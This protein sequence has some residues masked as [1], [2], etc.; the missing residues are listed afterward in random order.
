[1]NA[2]SES[3]TDIF[4]DLDRS[5]PVPLYHQLSTRIERAIQDGTLPPGA[6]LENEIALAE[7]LGL[8]R[9]TVRRAIQEIVDKG[10]LVRRR[11]I[12]T[13]VV[14]GQVSRKMALTSLFDDLA[15]AGKNPGTEVLTHE[16]VPA[17]A[18]VAAEL[19]VP[20]GSEVLH[21]RRLR[22]SEGKPLAIMDNYLPAAH[23]GIGAEDLATFGLYQIL[24][25]RG[26]N[27]RVAQ[28]RIGARLASPVEAE[29]LDQRGD[30]AVLTMTR[31]AYDN[32]GAAIE[33]SHHTFR[34]DRYSFEVTLV[35]K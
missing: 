35:D 17:P 8:S 32:A 30:T 27:L 10:L 3:P 29:L 28:Q 33:F 11:G 4:M 6:K 14:Q 13:Q 15:R 22:L 21:I 24:R 2:Q 34:P 5:G 7:R 16:V 1:M 18:E 9:P 26:V 12:G 25:N 20:V 19:S 31:C 23:A